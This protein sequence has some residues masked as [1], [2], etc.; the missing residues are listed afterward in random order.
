LEGTWQKCPLSTTIPPR[1]EMGKDANLPPEAGL[2][3]KR[4]TNS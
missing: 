4:M 2:H 3:K 1:S